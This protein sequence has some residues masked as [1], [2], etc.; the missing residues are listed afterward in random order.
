MVCR[1][2]V[3]P[4]SCTHLLVSS[5]AGALLP[6]HVCQPGLLLGHPSAWCLPPE[7]CSRAGSSWFGIW[8]GVLMQSWGGAAAV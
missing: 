5:A 7:P 6:W 4:S 2:A 3:H 1:A 8:I